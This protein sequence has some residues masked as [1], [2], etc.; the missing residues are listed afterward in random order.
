MRKVAILTSGGD[1]PGMTSA[2]YSFSI[3]A[4]KSKVE[5]V[6]IEDGYQG[7]IEGRTIELELSDLRR[8]VYD[9]G[10]I[11][12]SSRSREFKESEA[13][14][15]KC[16]SFL[17]KRGVEALVVLGGNGSYEGALFIS[18]LGIPVILL[19]ATID[20]DVSS[21][22]YT[23]GFHSA[24]EEIGLAI[25]K[26]WDSAQSHSQLTFIEVMGRDC[27]DLAVL[28]A[29]ASPLVELVI[30]QEKIPTV[31][32]LKKRFQTLRK[33]GRKGMVVVIAEKI[34]GQKKLP[35][36]SQLTVELEKHLGCAVRGCVLGHTQRG[37]TPTSWELYISARFGSEAFK[38]FEEKEYDLALGFNGVDFY[39][40]PISKLKKR[41]KGA[42]LELIEHKNSLS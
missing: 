4:N 32:E 16:V 1:A 26:V 5:V 12:G 10:T 38:C 34:L 17:K 29:Y 21:T 13:A 22:E 36:M 37:A 23:I 27:S 3:L 39:K 30:T 7:L 25:K 6:Y 41:A 24:L 31:S 40:T 11:I 14:R 2:I 15:K 18:K 8:R 19:P 35:E 20:N 42:R 33:E 28:S 9:A